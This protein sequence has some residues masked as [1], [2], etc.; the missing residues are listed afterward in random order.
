ME[1]IAY[2]ILILI[3]TL[4]IILE[5]ERLYK[6]IFIPCCLGF[7]FI[8]RTEGFDTDIIDYARQ[9]HATGMELYYWREFIF[10]F[11]SRF[12]YSIFQDELYSF[13][14]MDFI[15]ILVMIRTGNNL[16]SDKKENLLD[17]L[18]LIETD[19]ISTLSVEGEV[20]QLIPNPKSFKILIIT[21]VGNLNPAI[22]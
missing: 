8:V 19:K 11:G 9:M 15:W 21:L 16:C 4:T 10:W 2:I 17:K 18:P 1:L 20:A 13:L 3:S 14:F 22:F 6:W 5:S 7:L 12:I